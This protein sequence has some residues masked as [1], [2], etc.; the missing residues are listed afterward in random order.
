MHTLRC[1]AAQPGGDLPLH[2][3]SLQFAGPLGAFRLCFRCV[4]HRSDSLGKGIS[5]TDW[6]FLLPDYI[7]STSTHV[8]F[9]KRYPDS[10]RSMSAERVPAVATDT[11]GSPRTEAGMDRSETEGTIYRADFLTSKIY[12]VRLSLIHI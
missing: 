8:D 6:C 1:T 4:L 2:K 10:I 7:A 5:L 12:H 9:R 3:R 11:L